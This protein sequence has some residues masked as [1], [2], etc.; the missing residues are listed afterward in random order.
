[1]KTYKIKKRKKL[2]KSVEIT[3]LEKAIEVLKKNLT[4]YEKISLAFEITK[5]VLTALVIFL[6]FLIPFFEHAFNS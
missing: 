3:K 4:R 6:A 1:M 5:A 2:K